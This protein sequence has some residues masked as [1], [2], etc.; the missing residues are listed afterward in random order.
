[1]YKLSKSALVQ[2]LNVA[3]TACANVAVM[4]RMGALFI[5]FDTG[6]SHGRI[7]VPSEEIQFPEDYKLDKSRIVLVPHKRLKDALSS[8]GDFIEVEIGRSS[9]RIKSNA[10]SAAIGDLTIN[11][12]PGTDSEAERYG[13]SGE[14]AGFDILSEVRARPSA[15]CEA[16]GRTTQAMLYGTVA[17]LWV[18]R[19]REGGCVAGFSGRCATFVGGDSFD[20]PQGTSILIPGK[21]INQLSRFLKLLNKDVLVRDEPN[22]T[23]MYSPS[24]DSAI[25]AYKPATCSDISP[26]A[27]RLEPLLPK[28]ETDDMLAVPQAGLLNDALLGCG[29]VNDDVAVSMELHFESGLIKVR[30]ESGTGSATFSVTGEASKSNASVKVFLCSSEILSKLLKPMGNE[31]IYIGYSQTDSVASGHT[32]I[33]IS[34]ESEDAWTKHILM[35]IVRF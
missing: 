19:V 3:G 23:I 31:Y 15:L 8:V 1:M 7:F 5:G 10:D 11:G 18:G 6:I 34:Q 13:F 20:F 30:S 17:G 4:R 29:S 16:I 32:I 22:A 12:A 2:A 27:R 35:P 25:K 21:S 28:Y 14:Y 24:S 33:T 26:L 9:V